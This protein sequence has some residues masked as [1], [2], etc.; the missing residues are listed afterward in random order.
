MPLNIVFWRPSKL[1][2]TKTLLLKHYYRRQ[3]VNCLL[4]VCQSHVF[5]RK[6]SVNELLIAKKKVHSELPRMGR[7]RMALPRRNGPNAESTVSNTELSEFFG[8]PRVPG[9]ELSEFLLAFVSDKHRAREP[10]NLTHELSHE[11]LT[12]MHTGVYTK[13]S[14]EMPT[15]VEALSV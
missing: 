13:M 3:G 14:T 9:R 5:P 6:S 12:K 4:I 7:L 8:H 11:G 1:V 2:S 10:R 15:K